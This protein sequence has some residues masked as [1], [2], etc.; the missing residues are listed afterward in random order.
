M[1]ANENNI[2]IRQ[3]FPISRIYYGGYTYGNRDKIIFSVW[4]GLPPRHDKFRSVINY[5]LNILEK[6]QK[7]Y[8]SSIIYYFQM[9]LI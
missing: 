8:N 9:Q 3:Y 4:P 1:I 6:V 2:N 5:N 7:L